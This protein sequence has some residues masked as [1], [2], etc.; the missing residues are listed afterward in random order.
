[1]AKAKNYIP[2]RR[3]GGKDRDRL[4]AKVFTYM[5]P[6]E[7]AIVLKACERTRQSLSA[8]V[9]RATIKTAEQD[10][11]GTKFHDYPGVVV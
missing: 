9:A 2:T 11:F 4:G 10:L 3:K 5:T 1:M 8:Y 7:K 6:A